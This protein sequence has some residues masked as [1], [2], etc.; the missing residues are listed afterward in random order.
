[1]EHDLERDETILLLLLNS[2]AVKAKVFCALLPVYFGFERL[3]RRT[4]KKLHGLDNSAI[5]SE[6]RGSN[7]Y[8]TLDHAHCQKK[9][10][11]LL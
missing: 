4:V 6:Q 8:S 9:T 10:L 2:K 5:F 11:F 1:M 3:L 7:I